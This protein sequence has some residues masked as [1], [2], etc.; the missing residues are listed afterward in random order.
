MCDGKFAERVLAAQEKSGADA[1]IKVDLNTREAL[2]LDTASR[3]YNVRSIVEYEASGGGP[4]DYPRLH[5]GVSLFLDGEG[6][7]IR[8]IRG[9]F[10]IEPVHRDAM[11]RVVAK[12]DGTHDFPALLGGESAADAFYILR[13]LGWFA[14]CGMI[15][16]GP[17]A[18]AYPSPPPE[19][20]TTRLRVATTAAREHGTLA[21][22]LLPRLEAA[23]A[24]V[25]RGSVENAAAL[26]AAL[27]VP[28]DG[29]NIELL[30]ET[31]RGA[32]R[33]RIAWL[34]VFPF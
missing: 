17:V 2:L 19:A 18:A 27:I 34:P 31:D 26:G 29:A 9:A 8:S 16:G 1:K 33:A 6:A 25:H 23:G 3:Q 15:S 28:L 14:Q 7:I 22:P 4:P 21:R 32:R 20:P 30:E 24:V 11:L 10:R 13:M 5:A 12:L